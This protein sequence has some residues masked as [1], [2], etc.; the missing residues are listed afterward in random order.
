MWRNA[1]PE[2]INSAAM[3]KD[4]SRAQP[5]REGRAA[6]RGERRRYIVRA[7]AIDLSNEAQ[8]K[9]QLVIAL[10]AGALDASH[11]GTQGFSAGGRRA[12]CDNQAVHRTSSTDCLHKTPPVL[13][14]S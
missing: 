11:D 6:H 3:V 1:C 12:A 5:D 10:P 8:R 13:H 9:M 2:R 4:A 14:L 7:V